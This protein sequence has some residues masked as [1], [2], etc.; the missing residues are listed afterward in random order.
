MI[1]PLHTA[2]ALFFGLATVA[3]ASCAAW[4][5]VSRLA[6]VVTDARRRTLDLSDAAAMIAA[7][8]VCWTFA[9]VAI[10]IGGAL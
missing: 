6:W 4:H 9:R 7:A 2:I 10:A 8:F 5:I 3:L 1:P